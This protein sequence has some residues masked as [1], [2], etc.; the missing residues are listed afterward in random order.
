MSRLLLGAAAAVLVA[1]SG[2]TSSGS[3]SDGGDAPSQTRVTPEVGGDA[4]P[5]VEPPAGRMDALERPVAQKLTARLAAR[6]LTLD[7]LSCPRW[8]GRAPAVLTCRGYLDGVVGDVRVELSLG[9]DGAVEFDARLEA[10]VL[11]T[12][13]LV[14]RLEDEGYT[15]VDCGPRPAYRAEVGHRITCRVREE[16][17]TAYVVAT[18][19]GTDGSVEIADY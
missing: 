15:D 10:G 12:A 2:C 17:R 3:V 19:T 6:G 8:Q 18:V 13:N 9:A 4:G 16:G 5:V 11:A 7:H 14:E 1:V